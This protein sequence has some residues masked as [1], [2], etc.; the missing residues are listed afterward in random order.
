MCRYSKPIHTYV[1]RGRI[2]NERWDGYRQMGS[3]RSTISY[4]YREMWGRSSV[5]DPSRDNP[6]W[7]CP[8]V[9]TS[10]RWVYVDDGTVM[11]I[12][13]I[14]EEY[15]T[16]IEMVLWCLLLY[17]ENLQFRFSMK[18]ETKIRATMNSFD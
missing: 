15:C 6:Q 14:H 10:A 2:N 13:R 8:T 16:R 4:I 5:L 3:R 17:G 11:W 18:Y 9:C 7:A 1:R 12:V